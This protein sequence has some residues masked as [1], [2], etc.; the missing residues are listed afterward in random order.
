MHHYQNPEKQISLLCFGIGMSSGSL[1]L[2][3]TVQA[4]VT[5]SELG[6]AT[7][8]LTLS[9]NIGAALGVGLLGSMLVSKGTSIEP[10]TSQ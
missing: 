6:T 2:V 5:R 9:R 3:L 10:K 8:A 7:G 4:G 1:A